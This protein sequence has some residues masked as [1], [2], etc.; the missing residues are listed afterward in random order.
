MSRSDT[1]ETVGSSTKVALRC[2]TCGGREQQFLF[3]NR[4]SPNVRFDKSPLDVWICCDC[5]TVF[6]DSRAISESQLAEYYS[7]YSTFEPPGPLAE[8]H[9]ALR[10]SQVSWIVRHFPPNHRVRRVIDI[11]C[12]S[13]YVLELFRRLGCEVRGTDLSSVM[14]EA[15]KS[16]YGIE[17]Y[18]G[19]FD[20]DRVD[21]RFDLATCIT[22]LEHLREPRDMLERCRR[23]LT[24]DGYLYLEVPDAARPLWAMLP[25]HIAFEHL[26]HW[27]E[28]PL[29][30]LVEASGFEV[31]ATESFQNPPDSGNPEVVLRML[32]RRSDTARLSYAG[33]NDYEQQLAVMREYRR[34]HTEYVAAFGLRLDRIRDRIAGEPLAI[35][36][37][38]DHTAVLL[39]TFDFSRF[40]VQCIFDGDPAIDGGEIMGIPIRHSSTLRPGGFR[41]FLLSTTNH[42]QEIFRFLKNR[43]P[44]C[45][46][47]GLY[48]TFD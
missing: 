22:V 29:G 5:G 3:S 14:I 40:D 34:R 42:E 10:E 48:T 32:A 8:G 23:V 7:A 24:P 33:A 17:G 1:V 15:L 31:V 16:T 46:V 4:R 2:A 30:R 27:S 35:Y 6:L 45:R 18:A 13:G 36:C 25:E 21:E 43:D 41:H 11:G 9:K 12:G 28:R 20:P 44:R 38:G 37:G 19:P 39:S 26:Y 47:Y